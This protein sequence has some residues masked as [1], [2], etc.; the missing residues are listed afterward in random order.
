MGACGMSVDGLREVGRRLYHGYR[1]F[2]RLMSWEGLV[3]RIN[4][5]CY[6]L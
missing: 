1:A 2:S 5:N 4:G 6:Q 3:E